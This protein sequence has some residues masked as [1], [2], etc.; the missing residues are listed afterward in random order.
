MLVLTRKAGQ[1]IIIGDGEIRLTVLDTRHGR[2]SIG[3]TAP[4]D[5]P[6]MRAELLTRLNQ[7]LAM[8]PVPGPTG[9]VT[10]NA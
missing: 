9:L 8:E 7:A 10:T 2:V 1:E 3:I 4:D 5:M 6:I